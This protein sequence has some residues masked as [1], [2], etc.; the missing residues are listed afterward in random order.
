MYTRTRLAADQIEGARTMTP[1]TRRVVYII[2]GAVL[3]VGVGIALWS[4][5]SGD[6]AETSANGCVSV[7][8]ASTTGGGILHYC[9]KQAESFCRSAFAHADVVSIEARPQCDLAGLT[10]AKLTVAG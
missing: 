1:R 7:N 5:L 6:P 9:G 3:A 10:K 2:V 8:V 4:G